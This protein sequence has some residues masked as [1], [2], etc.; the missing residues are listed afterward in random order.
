LLYKR[1]YVA[2]V[3]GTGKCKIKG[4]NCSTVAS[5]SIVGEA[6]RKPHLFLSSNC[7][8]RLGAIII[9][10]S[11]RAGKSTKTLTL[12]Q[13]QQMKKSKTWAYWDIR[14]MMGAR[15]EQRTSAAIEDLKGSEA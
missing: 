7:C 11:A 8:F 2:D 14:N 4:S 12:L 10:S 6:S 3:Y 9:T 15:L 5:G 13:L 1:A